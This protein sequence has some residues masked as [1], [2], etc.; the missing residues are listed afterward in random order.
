MQ[1]RLDDVEGRCRAVAGQCPAGILL[2]M[3]F[4]AVVASVSNDAGGWTA[5]IPADWGNGRTVFGGL[6][7]ALLV[8]GM[9]GVLGGSRSLPL[10]SLHVTF[11]AP[12]AAG[13][14]VGLRPELLRT[15]KS[16]AHARCDLYSRDGLGCTAVA[17]FGA[18][19]PSAVSLEIPRAEVETDLRQLPEFPYVPGVTPEFVQHLQMR[20]GRG[21]LPY[22]GQK[23]ARTTIF[24]RL[25]DPDCAPEDAL[26]ALADSIPTPALSMLTRP[27]PAAS[28]NWMLEL[29][30]HPADLDLNAWVIIDT[31]VRAGSDGYLSQTSTLWGPSGHAFSISH[32]SVAIFG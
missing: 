23:D 2:R 1:G 19:R 27:A 6:Q 5:H 16:V 13:Q 11:V 21:S 10:R 4:G 22:S 32:Q 25:R 3:E 18:D 28:L 15:G 31:S 30:G 9:R 17:I 7:A 8:R 29:L 24:A 14:D 12:I 26:I 20:I